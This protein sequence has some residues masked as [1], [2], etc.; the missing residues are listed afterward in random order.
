[1]TASTDITAELAELRRDVQYLKD[2]TDILDCIN[3]HARGCDRHDID[4]IR[5]FVHPTAD[6]RHAR[7]A[8]VARAPIKRR[9]HPER[10]PGSL[11]STL[12]RLDRRCP[13]RP[14]PHAAG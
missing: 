6:D 3:R 9:H 13:L 11:G 1:M 14:E 5:P 8:L 7:R 12:G 2:R 10:S 4:L